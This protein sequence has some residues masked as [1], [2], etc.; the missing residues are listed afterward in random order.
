MRRA[1][2]DNDKK[3][4]RPGTKFEP[5]ANYLRRSA[6]ITRADV[7]NC[8]DLAELE[9]DATTPGDSVIRIAHRSS[10][11]AFLHLEYV[12]NGKERLGRLGYGTYSG[13][14]CIELAW[15]A[16]GYQGLVREVQEKCDIYALK[17]PPPYSRNLSRLGM[18]SCATYS[19]THRRRVYCATYSNSV[20]TAG[21]FRAS[22]RTAS[23]N[24][25]FPLSDGSAI[26]GRRRGRKHRQA[27][28]P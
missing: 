24:R 3:S 16:I 18:L 19:P 2:Y 5:A 15:L 7:A 12:G 21:N 25:S 1:L 27:A 23:R 10:G 9:M 22:Q 17:D 8:A 11:P 20:M 14:F 4:S 13:D 6:D 26:T 28:P